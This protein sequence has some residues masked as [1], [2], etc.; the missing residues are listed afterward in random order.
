MMCDIILASPSATFGQPEINLGVPPGGG[1]TQ[2]LTHIVG[3][4]RA[5]EL[6]LTGRNFSAQEAE[7]WGLV[8][9]IVGEGEGKVVEEA[10]EMAEKIAGFGRVAVQAT[11]EL[12]NAGKQL[13]AFIANI[14]RKTQYL[15]VS[16]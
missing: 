16:L 1:G 12:V 3:K 8:N 10:V 11:K 5:M 4:Y 15:C 9:K 13:V 14:Y 6:M 7:R 2:R